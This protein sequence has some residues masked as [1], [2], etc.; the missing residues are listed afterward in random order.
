MKAVIYSRYGPP[1]ILVLKEIKKPTP[2]DNEVL[3]KVHAVSL[4][5]S[6]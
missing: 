5:S 4:N 3:I 1:D 2:R 6:D